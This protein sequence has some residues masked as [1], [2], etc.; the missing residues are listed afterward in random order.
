MYV[1]YAPGPHTPAKD[2]HAKPMRPSSRTLGN[3]AKKFHRAAFPQRKT[4]F[5]HKEQE[6]E[7]KGKEVYR[8][9]RKQIFRKNKKRRVGISWAPHN[10]PVPGVTGFPTGSLSLVSVTCQ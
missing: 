2:K 6:K 4:T 10:T 3:G 9:K 5:H 1:C 8:V 7:E